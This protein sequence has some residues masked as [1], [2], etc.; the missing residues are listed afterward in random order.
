MSKW[1]DH[2][3]DSELSYRIDECDPKS[4]GVIQCHGRLRGIGAAR[5]AYDDTI[6]QYPD[7]VIVLRQNMQVIRT[8][9]H[10]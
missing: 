6:K 9:E 7:R 8:T 2:P 4:G 3:T 1:F 10:D 5:A